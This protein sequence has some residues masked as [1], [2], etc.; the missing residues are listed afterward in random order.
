MAQAVD[1]IQIG[2]DE[3]NIV[4]KGMGTQET[5]G[6]G[7]SQPYTK[8]SYFVGNDGFM[9]VADDDISKNDV[10]KATSGEGKNCTQTTIAAD[11]QTLTNKVSD[12]SDEIADMN[13]VLGAKNLL[14][15]SLVNQSISGIT[16]TVNTDK[17]ISV[18]GD[19]TGTAGNNV[20]VQADTWKPKSGSY[21]LSGRATHCEI[22]L[23]GF[24]NGN[25]V[26]TIG[27]S[28][29][30]SITIDYD[31]YDSV[32]WLLAFYDN[33]ESFS[34]TVYPM[35]RPASIK[36]DT[37][38]PYSMTNREMTP[39]VQ[40]I[41][42]PN[43]LDNP[44][45]TVNQRGQSSY[46]A[47]TVSLDRWNSGNNN[48]VAISGNVVTLS[49][50]DSNQSCVFYQIF[51]DEADGLNGKTATLS[52]LDGSGNL[53]TVS[54]IVAH[55]TVWAPIF[56][57]TFNDTFTIQLTAQPIVNGIYRYSVDI[58]TNANKTLTIKA[59]KL[60]LGTVSTLANDTAPNYQQELAKCQRYFIALNNV[61]SYF[62]RAFGYV[63]NETTARITMALP[64]IM[65]AVPTLS[66]ISDYSNFRLYTK[67][68]Q[69]AVSAITVT[70]LI[71]DQ[72]LLTI[73]SSGLTT[74]DLAMLIIHNETMLLSA[75]L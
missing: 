36:D 56:S 5:L 17:S 70:N 15:N 45:F 28:A 49:P 66:A 63:T 3:R 21:K 26:K 55:N 14:P 71:D 1:I 35:L 74:S 73:T 47:N 46:G 48:Q 52:L 43:L 23:Q 61:A 10:L 13:N 7:A 32:H 64:E 16:L 24:L 8:G 2:N 68:G 9:Y 41:S 20:Y 62:A 58:T 27:Q 50:V 12:I 11:I 44:W 4:S 37:Y 60:E 22:Y 25:Y 19:G 51:E 65:R 33:T 72:L 31:G 39:Y 30:T 69:H 40:A 57:K 54:G 34:E 42:N 18:S 75:D 38:E 67:D 6:S 29:E 59:V 53:Y